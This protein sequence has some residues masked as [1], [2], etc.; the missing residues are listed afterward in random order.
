MQNRS[1]P[2][3]SILLLEIVRFANQ[4]AVTMQATQNLQPR[5]SP[6][7]AFLYSLVIPGMG[8]LYTG[9]KRG[10]FYM[11]AEGGFARWLFYSLEQ[12]F[13]HPRRLSRCCQTTCCF[14]SVLVPLR[15]GTLLRIL[16]TL[17]SMKHGTMSMIQ[18]RHEHGLGKW[19][20]KDLD[21]ALKNEKDGDIGFESPRRLEA[22]DLRQKANNTF[23]RAKFFLGYGNFEPCCRV[24]W[25]RGLQPN[26]SIPACKIHLCRRE[27]TLLK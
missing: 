4:S 7:E 24:L 11:A 6:N 25:K 21:P 17:R 12:C 8:Q 26:V 23:E 13:K 10:Y 14:L 5:K 18:K 19:Y 27:P 20:W 1:Q 16:N 2:S 22:F 15:I 9:A 3:I